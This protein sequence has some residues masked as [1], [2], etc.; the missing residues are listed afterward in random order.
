MVSE[1]LA[2]GGKYQ[3]IL[4][5]GCANGKDF[6]Q[7]CADNNE[8]EITGIDVD[9]Y[10][11]KQSNFSMIVSDAETI[12]FP[13]N[14]FDLTVSFGVLEHI[15]PIEKL[16]RVIQEINRVSKKYVI[17]VPSVSTVIEPH[18]ASLLW[19]LRSHEKK[20]SYSRLNYFSDE[21]WLQFEGFK[22]G[23]SKRF[24]HLPPVVSNLIIYK[25]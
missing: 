22:D 4:E 15:Q 5:V 19:Q 1:D 18:S 14:Y 13:D 23:K 24:F 12:D 9:D 10:G 25:I 6:V 20:K 17:V 16:A 2:S 3:R 11:L 21:A 7:L 8:I